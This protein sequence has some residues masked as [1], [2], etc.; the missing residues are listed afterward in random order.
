MNEMSGKRKMRKRRMIGKE[1]RLG[2]GEGEQ[3]NREMI[4]IKNRRRGEYSIIYN[5][6]MYN[7]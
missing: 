4:G 5:I 3:K 2:R 1:D 7:I 6:I